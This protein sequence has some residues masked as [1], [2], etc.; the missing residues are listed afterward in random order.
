MAEVRAVRVASDL[1][2]LPG[3]ELGV[4]LHQGLSRLCLELGELLLDRDRALLG[5]KRLQLGDLAF[6][7]GN[8]L[9]EIQI[10]AHS[11]SICP[12]DTPCPSNSEPIRQRRFGC[13]WLLAVAPV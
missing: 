1:R 2:L 6:E 12:W 4:S 9:F 5:G 3:R 7:L 10:G 13:K 11:A 8:R